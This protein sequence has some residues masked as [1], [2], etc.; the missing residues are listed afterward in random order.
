M[1][2]HLS[3]EIPGSVSNTNGKAQFACLLAAM[4]IMMLAATSYTQKKIDA[5]NFALG[6]ENVHNSERYRGIAFTGSAIGESKTI[7]DRAKTCPGGHARQMMWLGNSQLHTINQYHHG[8][9]LAPYWLRESAKTP[10]CFWPNGLSLPNASLQEYLVLSAYVT[11]ATRIDAAVLS[12]VF[13]DLREDGL[14]ADFSALMTEP[15][16]ANLTT[17]EARRD[18]LARFEKDQVRAQGGEEENHGLEG[19]VQKRF[20]DSLTE[21]LGQIVPLWV[22]HPNLWALLKAKLRYADQVAEVAVMACVMFGVFVFL[23]L[24]SQFTY[25]QF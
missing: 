8:Q 4:L 10:D 9:H 7:V 23:R 20:E 25:F 5:E 24:I 21:A 18:I 15:M 17:N 12:L 13:D 2:G 14:R 19:F 11:S 22:E 16:R 6:K 1:S 3:Q